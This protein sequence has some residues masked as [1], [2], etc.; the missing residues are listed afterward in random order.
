M[1]CLLIIILIT[2]ICLLSGCN[3]ANV[4]SSLKPD[5][6]FDTFAINEPVNYKYD[7]N[8]S[9]LFFYGTGTL[10]KDCHF[11]SEIAT[12]ENPQHIV[13]S[14][15]IKQIGDGFFSYTIDG[16]TGKERNHFNSIESVEITGKIIEIEKFAFAHCSNLIE[17]SIPSGTTRIGECAFQGCINLQSINIPDS[18]KSIEPSAFKGCSTL[19]EIIFPSNLSSLSENVCEGCKNL[20]KVSI[21]SSTIEIKTKAFYNC[22]NLRSIEIP[23]SVKNIG[24]YAF[25]YFPGDNGYYEKIDNFTI[26]GHKNSSAQTYAQKNGFTFIE[27]N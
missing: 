15:G 8:S 24:E 18:V 19:N 17:I 3:R 16:N 1:K 6:T 26:E 4:D 23:L 22:Q 2:Y 13:I 25:G 12:I 11:Y 20:K 9:T 7:K 21:L 27:L 10:T 14:D 5:N